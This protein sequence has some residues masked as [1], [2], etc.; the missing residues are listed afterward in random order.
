MRSGQVA[1]LADKNGKGWCSVAQRRQREGY[2]V[3]VTKDPAEV[4]CALCRSSPAVR[5]LARK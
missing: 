3:T 5:A 1:H 4:R 2:S